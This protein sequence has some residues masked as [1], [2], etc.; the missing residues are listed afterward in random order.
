[1]VTAV[2][3]VVFVFLLLMVF[4]AFV[5]LCGSFE[6]RYSRLH[7]PI[8]DD[9]FMNRLPTGTSRDIA[10][11]VR[12]IVAEQLGIERDRIYPDSTF[13]EMID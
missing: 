10:M 12:T 13:I 8:S 1:M 5:P 2:D 11:R 9:E 3:T 6:D 7:P 4:W